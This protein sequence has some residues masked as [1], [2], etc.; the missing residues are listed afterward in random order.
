M[1][2]NIIVTIV[3]VLIISIGVIFISQMPRNNG[4]YHII[5]IFKS[6]E[7]TEYWQ[8][9]QKGIE[10]AS[11]D[12]DISFELVAA[13]HE[14]DVED[15]SRLIKEAI[16]KEPDAI[17][18]AAVD[19]VKMVDAAEEIKENGIKLVVIDSGLQTTQYDSHVTTN[20]YNA[21][22]NAGKALSKLVPSG[23]RIIIMSYVKGDQTAI[24]REQGVKDGL[25]VSGNEY[26]SEIYYIY[27]DEDEA[28]RIANQLINYGLDVGGMV[29]LNEN[30]SVGIG[31]AIM[32]L[33]DPNYIQLIGFDSSIT[34]IEYLENGVLKAIVVQRPFNIGYIGFQTAVDLINGKKV[35]KSIDTG[36][37]LITK[38][39]MFLPENRELLFPFN[40]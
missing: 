27:D 13:N 7:M 31:R 19:Y 9:V 36:S 2:K 38:D 35:D 1:K 25:A 40:Y 34:E 11:I 15:Q 22:F 6:G 39:E 30:A 16:A 10:K 29:G 32:E 20:N 23:E 24:E 21:G 14:Y 3:T 28:Y 12:Y 33:D 4:P 18:L 8:Q 26:N 17:L 37:T 5:V